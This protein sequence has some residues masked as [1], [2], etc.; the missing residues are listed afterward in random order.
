LAPAA[1]NPDPHPT[2]KRGLYNP[3]PNPDYI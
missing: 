3:I 1:G 2:R